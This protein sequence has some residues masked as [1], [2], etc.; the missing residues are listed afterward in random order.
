MRY[1]NQFQKPYSDETARLIDDEVRKIIDDAYDRTIELLK[2]K[3]KELEI[4]AKQ[5][6]E[7]EI[8]FK[9]DLEELIGVRPYPE[10]RIT[11]PV[12]HDDLV[13]KELLAKRS[14]ETPA[15]EPKPS[16]N[17]NGIAD[18]KDVQKEINFEEADKEE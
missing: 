14:E 12:E 15:E 9:A 3:E 17:G 5:L 6:L 1:E 16:E 11:D 7:K 18:E 2:D 13:D 4:L 10:H 8:L